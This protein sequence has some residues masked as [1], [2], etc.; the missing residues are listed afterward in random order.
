MARR[1]VLA[2]ES[3]RAAL[4]RRM[5]THF[6]LNLRLRISTAQALRRRAM[7]RAIEFN[8]DVITVDFL[9][10]DQCRTR[11]AERVEHDTAGIAEGLYQ[12][13]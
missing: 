3:G 8:A 13:F 2:S 10:R 7:I 12:R 6:T 11:A 1:S 4:G 9:R 5:A